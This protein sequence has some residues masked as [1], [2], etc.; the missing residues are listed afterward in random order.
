MEIGPLEYVVI[1][2]QEHHF[3]D[4]IL[5][6]LNAIQQTGAVRVVDLLFVQKDAA[7]TV[8][9]QELSELGEQELH[10]YEEMMEDLAG[11]FTAEDVVKLAEQLPADT[12]AVILL[13]EHCWTLDLK[14][15]VR[16]AGG[17][18]FTGGMVSPEAL[19]Q[20]SAELEAAKEENHA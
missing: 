13:L 1:G 12:S 18:L 3:T 20:V 4:E 9:V 15:A 5:P 6:A 7:G 14:E 19:A 8:T 11:L 2:F 16:K 17:V 10:S